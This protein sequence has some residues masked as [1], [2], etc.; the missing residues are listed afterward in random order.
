MT[1]EQMNDMAVAQ[2]QSQKEA[3]KRIEAIYWASVFIWAGLVFGAD[4]LG[5]LP[6]IIDGADSWS[7]IFL[8]AGALA[9]LGNLYRV[10]TSEYPNPEAWDWIWGG[11]FLVLGLSGFIVLDMFWP[12]ILI[13][14]GVAIFVGALRRH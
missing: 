7:W 1:I 10:G 5:L 14:I 13:L 11:V 3:R 2:K 8:G 12:L 6:N 4:S 9:T